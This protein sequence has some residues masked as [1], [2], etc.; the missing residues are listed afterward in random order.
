MTIFSG[1]RDCQ[2]KRPRAWRIR[3]KKLEAILCS[4]FTSAHHPPP[5]AA[6]RCV[7][8]C[9]YKRGWLQRQVLCVARSI[10]RYCSLSASCLGRLD[11]RPLSCST[12]RSL[13]IDKRSLLCVVFTRVSSIIREATVIMVQRSLSVFQDMAQNGVPGRWM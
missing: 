3:A 9:S 11:R 6:R 12:C 4:I 5:P 1:T 2:H 10:R 7:Y 8:P 13:H